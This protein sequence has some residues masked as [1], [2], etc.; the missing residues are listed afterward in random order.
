MKASFNW[1]ICSRGSKLE[2]LKS[3]TAREPSKMQ[4][5]LAF[6]S[7][8]VCLFSLHSIVS[9]SKNSSLLTS[10][11]ANSVQFALVGFMDFDSDGVDDQNRIRTMIELQGSRVVAVEKSDG[12]SAGEVTPNVGFAIVDKISNP[13]FANLQMI[14]EA[15][16]NGVSVMDVKQLVRSSRR[17][18]AL[19]P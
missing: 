16:Q 14:K 1:R 10:K 18:G 11:E 2:Q 19:I 6:A 13:D 9:P 8:G 15:R 3:L 7:L 17:R 4:W 5:C 12:S